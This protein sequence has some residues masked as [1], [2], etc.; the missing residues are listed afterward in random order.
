EGAQT[1]VEPSRVEI[2]LK[3]ILRAAADEG[4]EIIAYCFMPDH[5]HLLVEARTDALFRVQNSCRATTTSRS[6][7]ACFGSDMDSSVCYATTNRLWWWRAT[8]WR[9]RSGGG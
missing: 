4:F 7:G 2:V 1:F 8:S 3:Q 6:L 5:L 9:T